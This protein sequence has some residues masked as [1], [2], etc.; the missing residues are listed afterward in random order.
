MQLAAQVGH[1]K[2]LD[3]LFPA[4][5]YRHAVGGGPHLSSTAQVVQYGCEFC[6]R[7][8]FC[9]VRVDDQDL[10]AQVALPYLGTYMLL[11]T[12]LSMPFPPAEDGFRSLEEYAAGGGC[13][14]E[15]SW[16]YQRQT[17]Q[18]CSQ[19]MLYRLLDECL[20]MF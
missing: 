20:K 9:N 19:S 5:G 6:A 3:V 17:F 12:W 14:D 8:L 1:R 13:E 10:E 16:L 15:V 18:R 7:M 4:S 11:L 2:S